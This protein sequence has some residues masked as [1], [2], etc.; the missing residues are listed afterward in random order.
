MKSKIKS[1]SNEVKSIYPCLK[2]SQGL[3]Q[4][5]LFTSQG[6]G[7]L[8]HIGTSITRMGEHSTEW[9]EDRFELFNGSIKLSN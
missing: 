3:N 4:M 1:G 8:L 9:A 7:T 6:T 5:V 2:I